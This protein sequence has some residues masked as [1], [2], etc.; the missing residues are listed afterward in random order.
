MPVVFDYFDSEAS[1]L[2]K[3]A[4]G[5]ADMIGIHFMAEKLKCDIIHIAINAKKILAKFNNLF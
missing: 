1:S 3:R 4:A 2:C 5:T